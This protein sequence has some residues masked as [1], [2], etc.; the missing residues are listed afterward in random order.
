M[1]RRLSIFTSSMLLCFTVAASIAV[2]PVLAFETQADPLVVVVN[3]NNPV[4]QLTKDQL[5]DLFMGK[6]IAFPNGD[7]AVPLDLTETNQLKAL[8]YQELVGLPLARVN[9]YWSRIKF[10]GRARPPKSVSNNQDVI[11]FISRQQRAIGYIPKSQLT[12]DL[13]VVYYLNE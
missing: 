5:I 12:D 13:K 7:K 9:A 10:T 2:K 8:F 3:K 4:K 6:Y 11:E 1:M